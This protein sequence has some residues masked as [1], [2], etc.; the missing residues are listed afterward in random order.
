VAIR[1][2]LVAPFCGFAAGIGRR[3][4]KKWQT[5]LTQEIQV[6]RLELLTS[7][8]FIGNRLETFYFRCHSY[9]SI[10]MPTD[11]KKSVRMSASWTAGESR[12]S[13]PKNGLQTRS[14]E[15]SRYCAL[16]DMTPQEGKQPAIPRQVNRNLA[17]CDWIHLPRGITRPKFARQLWNIRRSSHGSHGIVRAI[18]SLRGLRR[19]LVP[20]SGPRERV[21]Q[22]V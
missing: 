19:T 6:P 3:L 17:T 4:T 7:L 22:A 18:E 10:A 5:P 1:I 16:I 13:G 2:G 8:G 11:G 20:Q 9:R 12:V 15:A 14:E 21:L